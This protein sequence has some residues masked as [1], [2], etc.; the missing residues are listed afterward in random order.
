M[1]EIIPIA[2]IKIDGRYLYKDDIRHIRADLHLNNIMEFDTVWQV[3]TEQGI[4]IRRC[5]IVEPNYWND[6]MGDGWSALNGFS[7]QYGYRGPVM[8]SSEYIGGR[9]A[10][11]ILESDG[12]Y[13]PVVAYADC[14]DGCTEDCD[15]DH[16]IGWV[17]AH[18]ASQS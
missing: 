1:R 15:A 9:M 5:D 10:E 13:V 14:E 4:M 7:G 12:L 6:W 3:D 8:H 2:E 11:T 17:L 18:K 16:V